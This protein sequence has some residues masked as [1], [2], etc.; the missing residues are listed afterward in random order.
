MN[1]T[2][3][4]CLPTGSP[5]SNP[6]SSTG[7]WVR[8]ILLILSL[9]NL[10]HFLAIIWY[11]F[12]LDFAAEWPIMKKWFRLPRNIFQHFSSRSPSRSTEDF[13]ASQ[14]PNLQILNFRKFLRIF[15]IVFDFYFSNFIISYDSK[16][17]EEWWVYYD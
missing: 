11:I 10:H 17:K 13:F 2:G 8:E 5:V 4:K 3:F 14:S 7:L 9:D 12:H 6:V 16:S 15:V 1:L